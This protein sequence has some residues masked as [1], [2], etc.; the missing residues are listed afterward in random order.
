MK[1]E[2]G[3]SVKFINEDLSGKV[4]TI[5]SENKVLVS[6]SDGF[7]HEVLVSEIIIINE[8]NEH[9][10]SIDESEVAKKI[11]SEK[12][13][14]TSKNVLSKYLKTSKYTVGGIVEID[15]H[16]E[17]LVEFPSRLDDWQRLHTQ[18]QHAKTCLKA[19]IEKRVRKVVLIH[20]VG[21]GVLKTELINYLSNFE[22]LVV[23]DGDFREYGVGATEVIIKNS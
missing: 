4:K 5:V 12:T 13:E 1:I 10:Y 16:L 20:G 11:I 6:C 23:Q 8:D 21:T 2:V 9:S 3:H 19:A 15:L 17:E 14:N 7:D 18:M 22:N